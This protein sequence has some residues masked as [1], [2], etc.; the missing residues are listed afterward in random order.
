MTRSTKRQ[1]RETY[2]TG[3]KGKNRV[4]LFAQSRDGKL[5]L[6]YRDGGGAKRRQALD[7][8]DWTLAKAKANE[9]AASLLKHEVPRGEL[10]LKALFDNYEREV[11]PMKA[12]GTQKHDHC[13]RQLFESCWGSGARVK[14]L[15]RRD[16]DRFIQQRR[17]GA[18]RPSGGYRK[19]KGVR[20][21]VIEYD[22]RFLLAVCN[23][24]ET[25]RVNGQPLLDRNP[26]RGFTLPV[27]SN[28]KRPIVT[29]EEFVKL[30]EA[31][32]HLGREV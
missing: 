27:E 22:L 31:A 28:P 20:D 5:Y 3:E 30:S 23:W 17:N 16:W 6:E 29:D 24:A 26:F 13:A 25:V 15:D 4:R 9:L 32:K 7:E 12:P 19:T 10:T 8:T 21:R 1:G 18:L 2:I 11:T 14:N